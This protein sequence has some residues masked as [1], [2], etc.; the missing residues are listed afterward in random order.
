VVGLLAVA[1]GCG[2]DDE[3][4]TVGWANDVCSAGTDWTESVTSTA[5]SLSGGGLDAEELRGAVDDLESATKDFADDLRGLGSPETESGAQAK[6]AIDELAGGVEESVAEMKTAVQDVSSAGD[7]LEAIT[8]V[9]AILSTLGEQVS[10]TL[11]G[12]D[13]VDAQGELEA[14]FQE[15]DACQ[16]LTADE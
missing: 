2:G 6:S 4:A 7:V 16:D 3:S 13:T 10:A 9:G 12:L 14:A 15:A 1:A 5:E 8:E 11:A